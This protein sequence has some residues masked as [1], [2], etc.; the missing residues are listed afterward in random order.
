MAPSSEASKISEA[1][2]APYIDPQLLMGGG[3][4]V[5]LETYGCQMNVADSEVVRAL[6]ET[7]GFERAGA[8]DEAD[9]VLLN[10]CAIREGAEHKIWQRL[11]QIRSSRLGA[12]AARH[13]GRRGHGRPDKATRQR[14]LE[15]ARGVQVVGLLGCM[16][17]RLKGKLLEEDRL[18]DLVCGPDAYRELP[19]LLMQASSGQVRPATC[20]LPRVAC[21]GPGEAWGDG[22]VAAARHASRVLA[23]GKGWGRRQGGH[24]AHGAAGPKPGVAA[25]ASLSVS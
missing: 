12:T 5:Y 13:N 22:R 23:W 14:G 7:A 8:I 16:A 15:D 17:E 1:N 24:V 6:L 19:R 25:L 9:V 10:T 11:R 3:R 21:A 20:H 2:P 4:R 18:L